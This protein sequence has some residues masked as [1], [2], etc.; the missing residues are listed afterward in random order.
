MKR[1]ILSLTVV[2]SMVLAII[3]AFSLTASAALEVSGGTGSAGDPYKI[4]NLTDLEAF[5][6]YINDGNGSSEYFKLTVPIDMSSKY[7]AG[8]GTSWTPIGTEDNPFS[9]TFDGGGVEISRLYI[10]TTDDYQGLFGY[11][12]GTIKNL[13]VSGSVT[14][15]GSS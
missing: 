5:C 15:A 2:L 6:K 14:V 3:P 10:S 8:I 1:R 12:T 11:S 13:T 4:A 9:G 7:S